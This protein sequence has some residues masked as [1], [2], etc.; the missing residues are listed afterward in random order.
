[1]YLSL[2]PTFKKK[3]VTYGGMYL[4][5]A[6]ILMLLLCCDSDSSA[7]KG[8]QAVCENKAKLGKKQVELTTIHVLKSM[9]C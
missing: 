5:D 2:M 7:K 4:L 3:K 6:Y 1:M 9:H 8:I